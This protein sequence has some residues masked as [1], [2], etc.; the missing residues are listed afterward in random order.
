M[1]RLQLRDVLE[2]RLVAKWAPRKHV[3]G[4]RLVVRTSQA[5]VALQQRLDFGRAHEP[6]DAVTVKEGF[7]PKAITG[8]EE[9]A[10][11][12]VPDG[13]GEHAIQPVQTLLAELL[14]ETQ[15]HFGIGLR[16]ELV[17]D[18]SELLRQLDVV[19]NLPVE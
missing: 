16:D 7:N 13:E 19:I 8:G 11:P 9:R 18:A 2:P 10:L 3:V 17:P 4:D 12:I 15:Q 5:W 14:V 1:A 6:L